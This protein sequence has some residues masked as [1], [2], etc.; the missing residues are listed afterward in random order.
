MKRSALLGLIIIACTGQEQARR[1]IDTDLPSHYYARSVIAIQ[2]TILKPP[3]AA[4]RDLT[5]TDRCRIMPGEELYLKN[6]PELTDAGAYLVVELRHPPR[7]CD[8]TLGQ[9][10]TGHFHWKTTLTSR[11]ND[12]DEP[13]FLKLERAGS[14]LLPSDLVPLTLRLI[15][16]ETQ[17]GEIPTVSGH[18]TKQFFRTQNQGEWGSQEPIPE[19][20]WWLN[21]AMG[22]NGVVF[23]DKKRTLT[24]SFTTLR[25]SG[26]Y[27]TGPFFAPLHA[28]ENDSLSRREFAILLAD[29]NNGT[30]G[31]IGLLS[32][33]DAQIF[34]DWFA[35]RTQSPTRLTVDWNLG[36]FQ[37]SDLANSPQD[38]APNNDEEINVSSILP[39]PC[40][41][42]RIRIGGANL[43]EAPKA[44]AKVRQVL[45]SHAPASING[46][47]GNYYRITS[48]EFG[49]TTSYWIFQNDVECLTET[50]QPAPSP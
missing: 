31:A 40:A 21:P 38:D 14:S 44:R 17:L 7:N 15:Q 28:L 13:P 30:A 49:I 6:P 34:V 50:P 19:G 24:G 25:N 36:S 45:P 37:E 46:S 8:K 16:G 22:H 11:P 2:P 48:P 35:D 23:A 41:L 32:L 18:P 3:E 20:H 27:Y 47:L 5:E 1:G 43:R 9:I 4:A 39:P 33:A 42:G 12:T 26:L 29:A 10:V